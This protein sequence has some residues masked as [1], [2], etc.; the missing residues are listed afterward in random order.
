MGDKSFQTDASDRIVYWPKRNIVMCQR[1]GIIAGGG[2]MPYL[3]AKA[4]RTQGYQIYIA[5]FQGDAI[6]SLNETADKIEWL[7]LGEI[8]RLIQF[9]KE[10]EVGQAVIMG[11]INKEKA[12][13]SIKLDTTAI[14]IL[15]QL[16]NTHDDHLLRI[17]AMAL[18]KEG[19]Q[20]Q[21]S[22]FLFPDY[23]ATAGCWTKRQPNASETNDI[24]LGWKVAKAI[25]NL[26]IGQCVVVANGSVLAV[27]AIEGTDATIARGG[28]LGHGKAVAIKVS[29]PNQDLRFDVPTVGFQTL[30]TMHT[31]GVKTL[32]I[33]AGKTLVFNR[34][35]M[36]NLADKHNMVVVALE[37][38]DFI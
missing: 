15:P 7:Q 14:E 10:Y 1:I 17:F 2:Q 11:T 28:L 6:G 13:T 32:A 18:E 34:Q 4:A 9:F 3:F 21:A 29:K 16:N 20:I 37:N 8:G 33:E 5:A 23:L 36:V 25:G 22:T 24:K 31:S 26:D 38:G 12:L 19:I 35:K 30:E 27:E